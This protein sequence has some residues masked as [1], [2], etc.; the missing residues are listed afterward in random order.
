MFRNIIKQGNKL[1]LACL[2]VSIPVLA[3]D[4]AP[5]VQFTVN[6]FIV[7]G[8][9]RV[10]L[11]ET[12]QLLSIFTGDHTGLDGLSE[13]AKELEAAHSELGYSFHKVI[14]PPQ[15]MEAG[16]VHLKVIVFTLGETEVTGNE[17]FSVEQILHSLPALKQTGAPNTREIA[18]SLT[19]ANRHPS[20]KHII[21]MKKGRQPNTIDAEI[22]VEDQKAWQVFAGL[23]NIGTEQTGRVRLT[24]GGQH[25]DLLGY[26]DTM[27]LS[28][29]TSHQNPDDVK[30]YGM[31]YSIPVYKWAS[32]INLFYSRSDVNTG[33]VNSLDISGAGRFLGG[34]ISHMLLRHGNYSHEIN[35]GLVDKFFE[36]NALFVG[37]N[38]ATDVRSRPLNLGYTAK[39]KTS[40]AQMGFSANFNINTGGGDKNTTAQ[41]VANRAGASSKW[42]RWNSS[43]Y[44]NYFPDNKW[45][46]R[47]IFEGQLSNKP[48]IPGEQFGL[49]GMNSVRGF[50]ERSVTSDSGLRLSGEVWLPPAEF[51]GG[52]RV[53]AFL[54]YGYMDRENPQAG[55]VSSDNIMSTGLGARWNWKENVNL[56]VD[57]GYVLNRAEHLQGTTADDG[58]AKWHVNLFVRY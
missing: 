56:A 2:F 27:T 35:A 30:Q 34:N 52:L 25:S 18:R 44:V 6:S 49:G 16:I 33:T 38:L 5:V 47:G 40:K 55:E 1:I 15:T 10:S 37:T 29:T 20:R 48:L 39:Y 3:E 11:S 4:S 13:A 45:L 43:A 17:Y 54:D 14:L 42:H 12:E 23:N 46:I 28:Y 36:N 8:D 7:E 57:Y 50:E 41:Y 9:N 58:N 31:S 19:L 32:N 53:L 51:L 22:R 26:D 21:N 24:A